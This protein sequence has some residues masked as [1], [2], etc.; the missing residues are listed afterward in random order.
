MSRVFYILFCTA[1][2]QTLIYN[3]K[4]RRIPR[5]QSTTRRHS[6]TMLG[7]PIFALLLLVR[8]G[9]SMDLAAARVHAAPAAHLCL[10]A[11]PPVARSAP[12]VAFFDSLKQNLQQ[13]GD[14]R[15]AREH[16]ASWWAR[17]GHRLRA[18]S[19]DRACTHPVPCSHLARSLSSVPAPQGR[20]CVA[21][22]P[23]G[24]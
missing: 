16:A 23:Q 22:P 6:F 8:G 4:S 19:P 11:T 2:N 1:C 14:F 12:P 24:V 17:P 10:S 7:G 3:V 9:V 18:H 13:L 15:C 5:N 20:A 21:H